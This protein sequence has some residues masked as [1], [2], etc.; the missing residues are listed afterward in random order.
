M[1]ISAKVYGGRNAR[2]S[3][4]PDGVSAQI[5][6]IG[7]PWLN[8]GFE[9][10]AAPNG[11]DARAVDVGAGSLT[12]TA[13]QAGTAPA[14]SAWVATTRALRGRTRR[15][16]DSVPPGPRHVIDLT[17]HRALRFA[18][19]PWSASVAR[20]LPELSSADGVECKLSAGLNAEPGPA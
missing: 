12:V 8:I 3:A 7:V 4:D 11:G 17:R 15:S 9:P 18:G 10:S 5:D 19:C 16:S 20:R 13:S 14:D 2:Y 1:Q 6:L